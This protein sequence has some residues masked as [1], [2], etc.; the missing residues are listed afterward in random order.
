VHALAERLTDL[1]TADLNRMAELRNSDES[2][3]FSGTPGLARMVMM[4][5]QEP[6]LTR[7]KARY[8]LVL[9]AGRD[10]ELARTL[11]AFA[12]RMHDLARDIVTGWHAPHADLGEA[13]IEQQA[14]ATMTFVNG[15]MM[16]FVSGR[17]VVRDAQHLDELIQALLA[18]VAGLPRLPSE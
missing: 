10:P 17:P 12:S 5:A 8:E 18:G 2:C 9:S 11:D 15:V 3:V 16:S 1:D 7:T 4:S 13:L 6:W 14:S